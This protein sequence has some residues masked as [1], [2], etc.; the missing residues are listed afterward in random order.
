MEFWKQLD[1]PSILMAAGVALLAAV[2]LRRVY[3]RLAQTNSADKVTDRMSAPSSARSERQAASGAL[4]G[5]EVHLH[6]TAREL[7][8]Q[9]DSKAVVLEQWIRLARAEAE[10]L[11]RAVAAARELGLADVEAASTADGSHERMP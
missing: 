2:F 11:E 1:V 7:S 8:A 4:D 6:E 5:C 3:R 10:R 9:L